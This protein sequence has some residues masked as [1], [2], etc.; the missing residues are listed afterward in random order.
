MILV[1]DDV[2]KLFRVRNNI[3]NK[4]LALAVGLGIKNANSFNAS[5]ILRFIEL[6]K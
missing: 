3:A 4:P 6:P 2:T 1:S 5:A